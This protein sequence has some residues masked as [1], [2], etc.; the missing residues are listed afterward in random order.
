M[1]RA[2]LRA[3]RPNKLYAIDVAQLC[4]SKWMKTPFIEDLAK[5]LLHGVVIVRPDLFGMA[6]VVDLAPPDAEGNP[7][8]PPRPGWF[9][10]MAVGDLVQLLEALPPTNLTK[11]CFERRTMTTCAS[12]RLIDLLKMQGG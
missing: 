9:V 1:T 10:R 3:I 8:P 12:M 11:I 6:M 5:F 4:Y 2:N 7:I